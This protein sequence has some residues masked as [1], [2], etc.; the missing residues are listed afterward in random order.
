MPYKDIPDSISYPLE[1]AY[2][3]GIAALDQSPRGSFK[4]WLRGVASILGPGAVMR[5]GIG[6]VMFPLKKGQLV[7][8]SKPS[9]RPLHIA[10]D[11]LKQ[12]AGE[13][14][15]TDKVLHTPFAEA[16]ALDPRTLSIGRYRGGDSFK[17]GRGPF[18]EITNETTKRSALKKLLDVLW[19]HH[20]IPPK[21][22]LPW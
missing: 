16:K 12:L 7:L 21:Y 4:D 20:E 1:E 17:P 10:R 13:I 15:Y 14:G 22:H 19:S 18:E 5:G 11:E 3:R 9:H 6:M 8:S 2:R